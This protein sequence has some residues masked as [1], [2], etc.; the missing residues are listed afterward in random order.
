MPTI[1]AIAQS[2]RL[3]PAISIAVGVL[4]FALAIHDYVSGAYKCATFRGPICGL[5]L[6]A[7]D[8]FGQKLGFITAVTLTCA[9]GATLCWWGVSGLISDRKP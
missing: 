8:L 3:A 1:R 4:C 2:R 6:L 9:V 7:T 5:Y